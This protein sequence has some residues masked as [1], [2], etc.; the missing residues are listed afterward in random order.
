MSTINCLPYRHNL[1]T[2]AIQPIILHRHHPCY[3][4]QPEFQTLPE[5]FIQPVPLVQCRI[6]LQHTVSP[7]LLIAPNL[8]IQIVSDPEFFSSFNLMITLFCLVSENIKQEI[9]DWKPKSTSNSTLSSSPNF[10][11]QSEALFNQ[12]AECQKIFTPSTNTGAT[13]GNS[14]NI[15]FQYSAHS[16]PNG[17]CPMNN[18]S[19]FP[20]HHQSPQTWQTAQFVAN[21]LSNTAAGRNFVGDSAGHWTHGTMPTSSFAHSHHH[22]HQ[23]P[24]PSYSTNF[25][26]TNG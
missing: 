24:S 3:L 7:I 5:I 8:Q 9:V 15:D 22:G 19:T 6:L 18:A 21:P 2:V 12:F 23:Y 13:A 16:M 20:V 25:V 4:H 26:I 11:N 10:A 14:T 1:A 17:H